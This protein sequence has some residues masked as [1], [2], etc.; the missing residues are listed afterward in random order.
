MKSLKVLVIF[1]TV[2]SFNA[3]AETPGV[4]CLKLLTSRMNRISDSAISS[5]M[6]CKNQ[7]SV[8]AMDSLTRNF[9]QLSN[10]AVATASKIK[11]EEGALCFEA[12]A[13]MGSVTNRAFRSCLY[14]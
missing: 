3:I 6:K 2:L 11:T 1:T 8:R 5:A 14:L 7:Y 4:T 13:N 10:S 12:F 9:H